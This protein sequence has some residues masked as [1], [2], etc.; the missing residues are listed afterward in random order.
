MAVELVITDKEKDTME[1]LPVT[2]TETSTEG[3]Y[4]LGANFT[5]PDGRPRNLRL[6]YFPTFD[7]LQ[8]K[9]EL[10]QSNWL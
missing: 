10:G 8:N 1:V 4:T 9:F 7:G 5:S 2:T 6:R 3:L